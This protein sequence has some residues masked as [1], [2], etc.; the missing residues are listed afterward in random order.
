ML[1][2][3]KQN[4]IT[5]AQAWDQLYNRHKYPLCIVNGINTEYAHKN[6]EGDHIILWNNGGHITDDNLQMLYKNS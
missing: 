2:P 6:M 5:D 1:F 3:T 4:G